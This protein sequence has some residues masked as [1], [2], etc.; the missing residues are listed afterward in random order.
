MRKSSHKD[1][2]SPVITNVIRR[3]VKI[4]TNEKIIEGSF[5]LRYYGGEDGKTSEVQDIIITRKNLFILDDN[6][7][8]LILKEIPLKIIYAISFSMSSNEFIFHITQQPGVR[9]VS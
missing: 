8:S 1:I 6:T 3:F 9:Y 7:S 5:M 4:K 2:S